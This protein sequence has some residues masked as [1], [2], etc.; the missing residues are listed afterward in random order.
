VGWQLIIRFLIILLVLVLAAVPL[1][2]VS[3]AI[4]PSPGTLRAAGA[5]L[6]A[7]IVLVVLTAVA[8]AIWA[9]I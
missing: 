2:F 7:F 8:S 4:R 5:L 1:S 9:R 3:V 6:L